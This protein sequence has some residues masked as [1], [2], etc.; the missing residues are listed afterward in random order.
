MNSKEKTINHEVPASKVKSLQNDDWRLLENG[1]L[2]I[3]AKGYA[4][5]PYF[6]HADDGALVMVCTTGPLEEGE[7]GQHIISLRSE[8]NGLTWNDPVKIEP[9]DGPEASWAVLHKTPSGRLYTFYT[10]NADNIRKVPGDKQRY[11][12][13]W[14]TR[15]DTLGHLAFKYSDDHGR[16]WTSRRWLVPIRKFKIDREN[17]SNGEIMYF[18]NVGKPFVH[19]D[20]VLVPII[21]VGRFGKGM[22][23]ESEGALIRCDNIQKETDPEKLSFQTLP[24]GDIGIRAP[25]GE[26]PVSEEHSFA[27]LSDG[28][29]FCVFRTISGYS[30][31]C[32]SSDGGHSWT[33]PDYMKYPDGRRIK[34]PRAANF[35]WQL[36]G[37]RYLYWFHNNSGYTYH[38]RNPAWV[39]AGFEV[40]T[41]QGK[42]LEFSQPEIM[43]YTLGDINRRMSYPDMLE[44]SDG[45][46][47]VSET[48][49]L[50]VRLHKIPAEFVNKI[51]GQAKTPPHVQPTDIILDW[52]NTRNEASSVKLPALP[53]FYKRWTK[54]SSEL[55]HG[56]T[57]SVWIN[58]GKNDTLLDNRDESG[59][60]FVIA[61]TDEQNLKIELCDGRVGSLWQSTLKLRA[62]DQINTASIILDGK[63]RVISMV[64]NGIFEDGGFIRDFGWGKLHP[65][66][67]HV[68]AGEMKI[69]ANVKQCRIYNRSLLTAEAI[70][71][72]SIS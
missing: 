68:N 33:K 58:N 32:Y 4:D 57:L 13:G 62:G 20:K 40:D 45:S 11:P 6:L 28:S 36:S 71:E 27:V 67:Q 16:T 47:L 72:H 51:T 31:C 41:P 38:D 64:I 69:S 23:A 18:W 48:E 54:E 30:A 63:S 2:V 52:K 59:T 8:D 61:V 26:E 17:T 70:A 56:I 49:K 3:A 39:L 1:N 12:D 7:F 10:Y 42:R 60:G 50:F 25:Q 21:K 35:I 34:N 43:L 53:F 24:G 37:N 55:N 44:L 14:C 65:M 29:L 22:F 19:D 46:L 5:Q 66:L 9:P 15:V